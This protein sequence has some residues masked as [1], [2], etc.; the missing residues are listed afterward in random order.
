[1]REGESPVLP[2]EG[3]EEGWGLLVGLELGGEEKTP[4]HHLA[5]LTCGLGEEPL[6]QDGEQSQTTLRISPNWKSLALVSTLV[7]AY[8][9]RI[10]ARH[11]SVAK[12]IR[13]GMHFQ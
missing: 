11:E 6:S 10:Q 4:R 12:F 2:G 5:S 7:L 8:S 13:N 3:R 9:K 1:L